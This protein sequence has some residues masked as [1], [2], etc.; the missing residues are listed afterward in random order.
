MQREITVIPYDESWP[1]LYEKEK[2]L[3]LGI[4]GNLASDIQ[5]FGS[6]CKTPAHLAIWMIYTS[7]QLF[8]SGQNFVF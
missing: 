8:V 3:L 1:L 5:H 4:F 2:S 6:A 7:P